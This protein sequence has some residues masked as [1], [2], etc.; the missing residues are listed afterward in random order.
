MEVQAHGTVVVT[1][2]TQDDP[3]VPVDPKMPVDPTVFR[4]RPGMRREGPFGVQYVTIHGYRRAYVRA[5]SGPAVLLIHGIGDSSDTWRPVLE[6]LAETHTVIAPDL[7]GLGRSEKPRADYSIAAYANGMRSRSIG[8]RWSGIP[9]VVAWQRSSPTSSRTAVSGWS[10][11]A[12]AGSAA[13]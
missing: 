3:G 8:S 13:R 4:F 6:G 5:G 9:W 2:P 10:W 7:L 11:W 12:A 1:T